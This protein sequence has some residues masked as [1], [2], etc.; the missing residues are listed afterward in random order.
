M[1]LACIVSR[2]FRNSLGTETESKAQGPVGSKSFIKSRSTISST[3]SMTQSWMVVACMRVEPVMDIGPVV[4]LSFSMR[5]SWMISR[6]RCTCW[7]RMS[8][9][10]L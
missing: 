3:V 4:R 10:L 5:G 7:H 2:C 6:L 1:R 9:G 8:S